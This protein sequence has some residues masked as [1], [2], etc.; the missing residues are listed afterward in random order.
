MIRIRCDD[1]VVNSSAFSRD[2]AV[3]R[4]VQIHRWME[5]APQGYFNYIPTVIV[6]E[7]KNW[8]EIIELLK[9]ETTAHKISPQIHGLEHIDYGAVSKAIIKD[10]LLKCIDWFET[11]LHYTPTIWASPWGAWTRDMQEI[12]NE[13]HLTLETTAPTVPLGQCIEAIRNTGVEKVRYS[14]PLVLM[15]W[16]EKGLKLLRLTEIVRAGS[17]DGAVKARPDLF[18]K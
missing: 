16:W 8:P 13:L 18:I 10:H 11:T 15:H 14:S 1:Y 5:Q 7:I 17:Y 6:S 9:K 4:I 12:S 2:R 3:K